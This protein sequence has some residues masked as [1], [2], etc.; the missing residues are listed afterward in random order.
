MSKT[1]IKNIVS[2]G[3]GILEHTAYANIFLVGRVKNKGT[4]SQLK[5]FFEKGCILPCVVNVNVNVVKVLLYE[6]IL[7]KGS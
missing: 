4:L 7:S 6:R 3:T 5:H 2:N 1:A